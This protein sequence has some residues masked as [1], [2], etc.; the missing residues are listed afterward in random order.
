[1]RSLGMMKDKPRK[2]KSS[3]KMH[4]KLSSLEGQAEEYSNE[5]DYVTEPNCTASM[6]SIS[7]KLKPLFFLGLL[8]LI[9]SMV[10]M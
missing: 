10:K 8:F 5:F 6:Y 9:C 2:N 3:L 1:M 7:F 4:S